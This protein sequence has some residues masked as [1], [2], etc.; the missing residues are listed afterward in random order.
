MIA[1]RLPESFRGGCSFGAAADQAGSLSRYHIDPPRVRNLATRCGVM[2]ATLPEN[3]IVVTL[4][5]R[6]SANLMP[7]G[8]VHPEFHAPVLVSA[9]VM[10]VGGYRQVIA[11]AHNVL[12]EDALAGQRG[13]DRPGSQA[14][15]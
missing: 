15:Q 6:G 1:V 11:D 8:S 5:M 4:I 10:G 3:A 13:A 2:G 12:D 7:G 14:R 9:I